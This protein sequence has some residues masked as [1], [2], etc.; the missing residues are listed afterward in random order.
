MLFCVKCGTKLTAE[1]PTN[2][3]INSGEGG[4]S[5]GGMNG[6]SNN[7]NVGNNPNTYGNN[8]NPHANDTNANPYANVP[9]GAD[10]Q[11]N[12]PIF[13]MGGVLIVTIIICATI[14]VVSIYS[15]SKYVYDDS[16]QTVGQELNED[17]TEAA[18]EEETEDV[19]E[20]ETEDVEEET[21]A[22]EDVTEAAEEETEA[23]QSNGEPYDYESAIYTLISG[24]YG[25]GWVQTTNTHDTSY[26]LNYTTSSAQAFRLLG[27]RYWQERPNVTFN[28]INNIKV[29]K[30]EKEYDGYYTVYI[31]YDF[32]LYD[33]VTGERVTKAE[34]AID[35]VEWDGNKYILSE[36]HWNQNL[37]QGSYITINTFK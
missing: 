23:V 29:Y 6:D 21:E 30:V 31:S 10:N 18:V 35:K 11:N 26:M 2:D 4:N 20:A 24:A 34:L 12:M 8:A 27:Q 28:Y 1:K 32:D 25:S 36:H 14:I 33:S 7:G 3:G 16:T 19:A 5:Y 37:P 17:E 9:V 13:I 15:G 22:A